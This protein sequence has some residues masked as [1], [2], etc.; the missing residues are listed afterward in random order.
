[1]KE[2]GGYIEFESYHGTLYHE[3][4][5][6]L[7]CGRNC[8]AYLIEACGIK[9]IRL[10]YFLCSSV[11]N[12]CAKYGVKVGFYRI[13]EAFRPVIED[14]PG[15][16]E[17]LYIVNYYG[18]LTND[19]IAAYKRKFGRVITDNSQSYFQRPPSADVPTLYTCRK[20]F[21]VPD[22][23]F[24]YTDKRLER[25]LTADETFER[26]HYILG[27]FERSA[28]EFYKES[29]DNNKFFA[30]EPIKQ[31]SKLTEDLLR[32]FEYERIIARRTENFRYLHDRLGGINKLA[33]TVPEGA[34]MY[35][36]YLENGA[37][38]KKALC[39]AKIFVPTLWGDVFESCDE[40]SL[41]YDYAKNIVPLP[42]DQ[43]YDSEDM[44]I[45]IAKLEK[46]GVL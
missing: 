25:E 43:R 32:S 14:A 46:E 6:K 7:N 34:F 24:L 16:D 33:L 5:V 22:G 28:G 19:E 17:W 20:Y 4:A 2:I 11:K 41:E 30:D 44:D 42:I 3:G 37:E 38:V 23:A 39:A 9:Q 36:L 10:P 8:L 18:Q 26:I 15:A 1:M 27:R 13:D 12:L 31:M 29:A 45:I 40:N 35:P 21:G